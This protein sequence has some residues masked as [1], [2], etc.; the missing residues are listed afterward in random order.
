MRRIPGFR[1]GV[2]EVLVLLCCYL[3]YLG[4]CLSTF[5][6]RLTVPSSRVNKSQKTVKNSKKTV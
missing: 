1:R 4:S 2:V 3:A 5:Q 6:D